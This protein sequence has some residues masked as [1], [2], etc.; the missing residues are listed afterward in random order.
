MAE[1]S[2][3]QSLFDSFDR[4]SGREKIM[5]GGLVGAFLLT[6]L[7][8]IWL[9]FANQISALEER[10]AQARSTM[11]EVMT[12]KDTYLAQKAKLDAK[13]SLLD[14]NDVRLV[15]LMENEAKKLGIEIDDFKEDKRYVT[16]NHRRARSRDEGDGS[17]PPPK[18]KDLV[19]VSQTVTM[20]RISLEQLSNFLAAL[21]KRPEPIRVTDLNVST[22]TSDRQ[23]LRVVK[24]K[25]STYRNEE[26]KL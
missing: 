6:V 23:V 1:K 10:N 4:L 12:L 7:T 20:R 16:E 13:K 25:V 14:N 21:Q 26:V 3:M 15:R 24:V 5:V 8:I 2:R 11:S 17:A 18:I 19:E 22:L 9:I